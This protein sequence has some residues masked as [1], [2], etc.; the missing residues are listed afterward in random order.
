MYLVTHAMKMQTLSNSS[1]RHGKEHIQ[2]LSGQ[3]PYT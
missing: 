3:T 1:D 2:Q